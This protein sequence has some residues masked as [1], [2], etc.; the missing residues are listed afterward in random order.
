[1]IPLSI[2]PQDISPL[3]LHRPLANQPDCTQEF[4]DAMACKSIYFRGNLVADGGIHR[5][6]SG[7]KGDK[8]CWY[9]FHGMAGAFG[10]WSRGINEKWSIKNDGLS[11][12]ETKDLRQQIEKSRESADAE[13]QRK[14]EETAALALSKWNSLSETGHSPY[15]AKKKVE[16]YG[17]RFRQD[18]L[19]I[20]LRDIAGKLWSLQWISPDG[21]KRFLTGGRKKGCFH[22]IG[23][24]EDGQPIYVT[25]GYATGASIYRATQQLTVIAF[26]AGNLDSVIET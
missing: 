11:Y 23:Q 1:M 7:E 9:V 24:L 3:A 2:E 4:M 19:I 18:L 10:D 15:L 6:S 16:P 13:R 22:L 21:T 17:V 5:F 8:D 12:S 25:E 26:D 20:P 14:Q